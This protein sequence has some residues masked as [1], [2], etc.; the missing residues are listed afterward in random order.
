MKNNSGIYRI[1][2]ILNNDCYIGSAVKLFGRRYTHFSTLRRGVH[3]SP[4]LQ[5]AY[6]KYGTNSFTFEL[7]EYTNKDQ[8]I[9]REQYYLDT[10]FPKYNICRVAGNSMGR[11]SVRK[12]PVL[13]YT[14]DGTLIR[15]WHCLQRVME[16][17]NISNSSKISQCCQ[18]KRNKCYGYVWRYKNSNIPFSIS[19]KRKG[20][21]IAQIDSTGKTIKTWDRVRDCAT[22][23]NIR[24]SCIIAAIKQLNRRKSVKGMLF[25]YIEK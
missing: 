18:G 25:K 10:L 19:K 21:P 8:L 7:L 17:L 15:K 22:D 23:L 3:H 5:N 2:N 12:I 16:Y 6:N 11:V 20:K 4:I 24:S 9:V 13:Q 1:R 14:L